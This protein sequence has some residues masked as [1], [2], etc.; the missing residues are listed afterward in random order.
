VRDE[1]GLPFADSGGSAE[2]DPFGHPLLRGTADSMCRL[3]QRELG[4]R[5]R[6]DKPGS[7][8]RMSMAH[9]S[10]VDRAEAA[11]VGKAA[12]RLAL[13][14]MTDRMVTIIRDRNQPYA[15]HTGDVGLELVANR[16][17]LLPPAY[18]GHGGW[19]TDVF[20]EYAMPLLGPQPLPRYPRL[21]DIL[22]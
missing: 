20:R 11:E 15:S 18:L 4:L 3:I 5:A 10:S 1:T 21:E 14:G 8:Q 6:F 7:L 19:V 9:A 13:A 12:V 17:R 2:L 22:T 16:Q